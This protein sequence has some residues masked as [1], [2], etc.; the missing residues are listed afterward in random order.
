[1][2]KKEEIESIFTDKNYYKVSNMA[3]FLNGAMV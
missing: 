1:M 2:K 3:Q